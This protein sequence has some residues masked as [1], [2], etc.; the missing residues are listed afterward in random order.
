MIKNSLNSADYFCDL[1]SISCM[2]CAS[3][4]SQ[5]SDTHCLKIWPIDTD[6]V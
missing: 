4:L 2:R 1:L 3:C 6:S 5:K